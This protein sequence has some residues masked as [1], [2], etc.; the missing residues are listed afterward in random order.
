LKKNISIRLSLLALAVVILLPVNR[1][2]KILSSNQHAGVSAAILSG[3][4]LP[5]PTPPG[6]SLVAKSGSPLPTPTPPRF[7]L[8]AKSGSPLPTPTPPGLGILTVEV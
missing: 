3:S 6:Y 4:P 5:T 7:S 1:S 8:V 2:V